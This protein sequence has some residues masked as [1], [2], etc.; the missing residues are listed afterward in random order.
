MGWVANSPSSDS[1]L[2]LRICSHSRWNYRKVEFSEEKRI[3]EIRTLCFYTNVAFSNFFTMYLNFT[4]Q[5]TFRFTTEFISST[6]GSAST[7]S[8]Y[9]KL[10]G[11]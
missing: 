5:L 1:K 2:G 9:G 7:Y 11:I 3:Y 6:V 4:S 8:E 10:Y